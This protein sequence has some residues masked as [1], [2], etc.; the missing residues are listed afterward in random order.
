MRESPPLWRDR[1]RHRLPIAA[2]FLLAVLPARAQ[3]SAAD[4]RRCTGQWRATSEERI[5]SCTTLIDSGHY[6][7][8]NLAILHDNR[9][10]AFR[11]KGDLTNARSDF[12]QAVSLNPSY[13]RAYGNRGSL[14]LAQRDFDGGIA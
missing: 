5:A 1:C 14:A 8:V 10:M 3:D 7:P 13:A 9:G 6:Q 4:E 2:I 11:A 12:D